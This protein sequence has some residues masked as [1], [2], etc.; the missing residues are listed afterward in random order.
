LR[1]TEFNEDDAEQ[2][3]KFD[4]NNDKIF[5]A[6]YDLIIIDE[7]HEGTTTVLAKEMAKNLKTKMFLYLSGTPFKLLIEND[8]FNEKNYF[9]F[10]YIDEKNKKEEY[11]KKLK[12]GKIESNPYENL[13]DLKIFCQN[14]AK[15][16]LDDIDHSL[17]LTESEFEFDEFFK[18]E[19]YVNTFLDRLANIN[20]E[21][22]FSNMPFSKEK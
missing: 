10:T 7:G 20:D 11:S 19:K 13:P 3:I 6:D 8:R 9:S 15:D 12:E 2:G 14:I 21:D 5:N 17:G 16:F 1:R 22:K 4:I 18:N